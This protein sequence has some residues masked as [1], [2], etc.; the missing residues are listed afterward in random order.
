MAIKVA[1]TEKVLYGLM[2]VLFILSIAA[3]AYKYG[4]RK[5]FDQAIGEVNAYEIGNSVTD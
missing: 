5:G 3:Q 2:V 4:K 1:K